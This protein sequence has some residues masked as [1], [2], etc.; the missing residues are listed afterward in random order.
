MRRPD[1][2]R[3]RRA[4]AAG[5]RPAAQRTW[6]SSAF[7]AGR[8]RTKHSSAIR[9]PLR[10]FPHEGQDCTEEAFI[11]RNNTAECRV[12]ACCSSH[13][14]M[15]TICSAHLRK[16]SAREPF[17]PRA[18]LPANDDRRRTSGSAV[19]TSCGTFPNPDTMAL[20]IMM[21]D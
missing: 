1:L 10:Y 14:C 13:S 15:G 7:S 8:P 6:H 18:K 20:I 9:L 5:P 2:A 16:T 3:P 17:R 21:H 12:L 19:F 4:P 11:S